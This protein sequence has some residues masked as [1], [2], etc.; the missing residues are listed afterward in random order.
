MSEKGIE[1]VWI[2]RVGADHDWIGIQDK[3]G[4]G[5]DE[6]FQILD[7]HLTLIGLILFVHCT[8][9]A[10]GDDVFHTN[11]KRLLAAILVQCF[12]Q[13]QET[14]HGIGGASIQAASQ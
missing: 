12:D 7:P 11:G 9:A 5:L 13:V 6:F 2:G 14:T 4:A 10:V 1:P 8:Q 3:I